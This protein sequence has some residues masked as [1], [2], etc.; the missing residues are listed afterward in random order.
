[1]AIYLIRHGE[2]DGNRRRVLQHPEIPLSDRGL[3]QA[4][5]LGARVADAGITRIL[6]SDMTRAA[7]TAQAVS[8]ATGVDIE[9]DTGLHERN[10]GDLRGVAYAD[11]SE[12]PFGPDYHPPAGESW[13]VFH[14]RVADV[15]RRVDDAAASTDGHLAVVTHG[16]VCRRVVDHHAHTAEPTALGGWGNTSLTILQGPPWQ[17]QLL[18]CTKHLDGLDDADAPSEGGA[19]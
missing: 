13:D 2:T 5:R 1:M 18:A 4:A 19:A 10:F 7:M 11:L 3:A 15:W 9:F 12:D 14:A 6:S 8:R 17:V 16:L